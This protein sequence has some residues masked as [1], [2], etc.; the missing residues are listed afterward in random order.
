MN[1]IV[2][3]CMG[4]EILAKR[5]DDISSDSNSLGKF[6]H[7]K[8]IHLHHFQITY[9][10]T[11]DVFKFNTEQGTAQH[12]SETS[13]VNKKLHCRHDFTTFLHLVEEYQ[14]LPRL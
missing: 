4:I 13:F 12:I 1:E 10:N 5:V 11:L 7:V 3:R 2:N 14:S 6:L 8:W 9:R